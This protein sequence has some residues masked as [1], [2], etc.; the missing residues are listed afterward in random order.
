MPQI[1][2][3]KK[4]SSSLWYRGVCDDLYRKIAIWDFAYWNGEVHSTRQWL[5]PITAREEP[6]P[7]K[8]AHWM[9]LREIEL[10]HMLRILEAL[11]PNTSMLEEWQKIKEMWKHGKTVQ[12]SVYNKT[13]WSV[14]PLPSGIHRVITVA[15]YPEHVKELVAILEEAKTGQKNA[16]LESA[17]EK[18]KQE[19]K[20]LFEE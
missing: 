4:A 3:Q 7:V 10:E 5:N 19:G 13:Y 17:V 16:S 1:A 14:V 8:M 15:F 18:A 20:G 2:R 11:R 9:P 12:G 6:K